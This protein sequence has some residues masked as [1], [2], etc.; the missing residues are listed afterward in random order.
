MNYSFL[1]FFISCIFISVIFYS[2]PYCHIVY[3]GCDYKQFLLNFA[4]KPCIMP[5]IPQ[6][7]K[8]RKLQ[9]NESYAF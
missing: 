1:R 8:K 6:K 2:Q 5:A 3:F 4:P 9:I 7:T